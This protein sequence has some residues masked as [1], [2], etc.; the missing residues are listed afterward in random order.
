MVLLC[1]ALFFSF[2]LCSL[3]FILSARFLLGTVSPSSP[4]LLNPCSHMRALELGSGVI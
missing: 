1:R 4:Y 3:L 2:Y